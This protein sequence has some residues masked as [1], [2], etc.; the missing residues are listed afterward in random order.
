MLKGICNRIFHKIRK[1]Y[2]GVLPYTPVY[3]PDSWRVVILRDLPPQI[4]RIVASG[5]IIP[6]IQIGFPVR[7]IQSTL[8]RKGSVVGYLE[9]WSKGILVRRTELQIQKECALEIHFSF[10]SRRSSE[11]LTP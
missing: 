11:P 7:V 4:G 6:L 8:K 1:M 9:L 3:A 10:R 5:Y 2:F